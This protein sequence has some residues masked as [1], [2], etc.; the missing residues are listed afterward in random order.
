MALGANWIAG[1][2]DQNTGL[3]QP[4]PGTSHLEQ[5]ALRW[6]L[7]VLQ[8]PATATGAFVTGATIANLSALAAARHAVLE[9]ALAEMGVVHRGGWSVSP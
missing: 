5:V 3:Y 8:L 2:W 7:D 4:T 6:L 9:R 1:A